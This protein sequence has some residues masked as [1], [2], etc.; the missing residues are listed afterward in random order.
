MAKAMCEAAGSGFA[1][2]LN[3]PYSAADG[4]TH[5]LA[6]HAIPRGLDNV[7]IEVRNDLLGD[8]AAVSKVACTLHPMIMAALGKGTE[9]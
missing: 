1:F 7:M 9:Q 3:Q 4:V 5:M 8:D 6:R 2:E